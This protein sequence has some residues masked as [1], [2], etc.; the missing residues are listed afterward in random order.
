M[1]VRLR[2]L[3]LALAVALA[4]ALPAAPARDAAPGKL[5]PRLAERLAG[6]RTAERHVAWV[7]LRDKGSVDAAR[8]TEAAARVTPRALQ[9]RARRGEAPG[10]GVADLALAPAQLEAVRAAVVRV[11]HVSRWLNA[12]SVEAT[13]GQIEA[14]ARLP[15]V[16]RLDLVTRGRR[17]PE[18]PAP[19]GATALSAPPA[20]AAS[21]SAID[22]G[23]SLAQL[24]PLRVPEAHDLGFDGSGVVVALLDG[25]FDTLGHESLAPVRVAAAHDFV[26]GDDDVGDGADRREVAHGTAVLSS[27][28]GFRPGQLVGPAYGAT[29]LL[30][31]TEYGGSETPVEEDNWTAAAEWAEALGADIISTS[32]GYRTFDPGFGGYSAAQM[33]GDTAVSTRAADLAVDHGIVVLA[34]AGNAGPGVTTIGAPADGHAVL[35]IGAVDFAGNQAG[36]SSVGPT[37]DL[38]TKPDL[39]APGVSVRVATSDTVDGYRTASGTSF[40]CPLAAG[41]AA[42]VLQAHPEYTVAQVHAVLRGTAKRVGP[43][44]NLTGWGHVDALAAVTAP[45]P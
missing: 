44:D 36:F 6:S 22:Y 40:A 18:P 23:E 27:I 17:A 3:A 20:R 2:P 35:A 10:V 7:F 30:A 15:F 25:G 4:A 14:L 26:S 11:R 39:V 45:A 43:P 37:A 33:D 42:L 19:A 16:E 21:A 28:G 9:R 41:V 34:S 12:V 38:R 31:R 29:Y 24:A 5:A 1:H 8:W 13:A 32:L